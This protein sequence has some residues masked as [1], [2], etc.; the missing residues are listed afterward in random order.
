MSAAT[1]EE[2]E[3]I[4]DGEG[5]TLI[6]DVRSQAE[7]SQ[8]RIPFSVCIPLPNLPE[9]FQLS[10]DQFQRKFGAGKPEPQDQIIVTCKVGGRA[11]KGCELLH[12][13]GFKQARAYMGSFEE[14]RLR[15]GTI[16]SD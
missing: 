14:W 11:A 5:E 7:F 9:A 8:G 16:E 15:G 1:F 4:I 3:A 10:S 12:S 6:V 2:L 13:L